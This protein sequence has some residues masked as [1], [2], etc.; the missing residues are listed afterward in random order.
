[1]EPKEIFVGFLTIVLVSISIFINI[2][3]Q[4]I[5]INP[6]DLSL[7][8][9]TIVK[10]KSRW[11]YSAQK[12]AKD[13]RI[14]IYQEGMPKPYIENVLVPLDE[15]NLKIKKGKNIVHI[16]TLGSYPFID[17]RNII[18]KIDERK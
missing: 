12:G 4:K 10:D 5:Y 8:T 7:S 14:S 16:R 11:I 3:K 17:K 1:M 9:D 2:P 13:I 15:I 18:Y 6:I